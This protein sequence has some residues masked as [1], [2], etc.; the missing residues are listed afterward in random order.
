MKK[1]IISILAIMLVFGCGYRIVKKDNSKDVDSKTMTNS[2]TMTKTMTVKVGETRTMHSILEEILMNGTIIDKDVYARN[3][4]EYAYSYEL[5]VIEE[6][7]KDFHAVVIENGKLMD[8]SPVNSLEDARKKFK[9][10]GGW[11]K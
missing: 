4:G 10:Y 5:W 9:P 6:E 3:F 11:K 7:G 2:K 1:L 8:I